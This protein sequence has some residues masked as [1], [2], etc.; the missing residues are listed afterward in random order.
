MEDERAQNR[1]C[2]KRYLDKHR[3]KHNSKRR[4]AYRA[5]RATARG[6]SPPPPELE[7]VFDEPMMSPETR[8]PERVIRRGRPRKNAQHMP[9]PVPRPKKYTADVLIRML[10]ALPIQTGSYE[11]QVRNIDRI[12]QDVKGWNFRSS[13]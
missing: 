8:E 10:Q 1:I 4:A 11:T 13:R 7:P 5:K 3:Q 9:E 12:Q 2:Q 6:T